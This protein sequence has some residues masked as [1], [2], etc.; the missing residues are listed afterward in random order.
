MPNNNLSKYLERIVAQFLVITNPSSV[1]GRV[2]TL[3]VYGVNHK[4]RE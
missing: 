1:F 3:M 4:R 2:V